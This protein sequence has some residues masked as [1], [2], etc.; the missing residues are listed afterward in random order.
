MT[1]AGEVLQRFMRARGVTYDQLSERT[2]AR[3]RGYSATY[4]GKVIRGERRFTDNVAEAIMAALE[5]GPDERRQVEAAQAGVGAVDVAEQIDLLEAKMAAGFE[6][7]SGE[8][9]AS[10][11]AVADAIDRLRDQLRP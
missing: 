5:L 11:N 9:R 2:K 6:R 1:N 8:L 7:L 10:L 3:G 4:L